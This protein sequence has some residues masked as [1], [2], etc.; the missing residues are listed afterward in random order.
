MGSN[1]GSL[2]TGYQTNH[3]YF[4]LIKA[5]SQAGGQFTAGHGSLDYSSAGSA[6]GSFIINDHIKKGCWSLGDGVLFYKNSLSAPARHPDTNIPN[7][8]NFNNGFSNKNLAPPG[9]KSG[10]GPT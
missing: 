8:F 2:V 5:L 4:L 9:A 6:K 1:G 10:V 3:F 7:I